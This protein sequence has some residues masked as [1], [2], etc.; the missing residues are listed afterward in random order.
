MNDTLRNST[1]HST[2]DIAGWIPAPVRS[3]RIQSTVIVILLFAVLP[4][5]YSLITALPLDPVTGAIRAWDFLGFFQTT[6]DSLNGA[7]LELRG[8]FYKPPLFAVLL[9]PLIP[10]GFPLAATIFQLLSIGM[11]MAV[12]I[13]LCRIRQLPLWVAA[14]LFLTIALSFPFAFLIDRGNVDAISLGIAFFAFTTH[15]S[16]LWS[17]LLFALS[18]HIKTNVLA[19]APALWFRRDIRNSANALFLGVSLIALIG[20][21]TPEWT[22][23]WIEVIKTR[24]SWDVFET[25]NGSLARAF[26]GVTGDTFLADTL[27]KLMALSLFLG[28]LNSIRKK[29]SIENTDRFL[30]LLPLCQAYPHVSYLYG[31]VYLPLTLVFYGQILTNSPRTSFRS[32]L[33]TLGCAGVVLSCFPAYLGQQIFNGDIWPWW[34][35]SLGLLC[36]LTANSVLVWMPS[37]GSLPAERSPDVSPRGRCLEGSVLFVLAGASLCSLYQIVTGNKSG[38]LW[39]PARVD[40]PEGVEITGT[41]FRAR[42]VSQQ[43]GFLRINCSVYNCAPMA[44]SGIP[45]ATGL[46]THAESRIELFLPA[47][48]KEFSGICGLDDGNSGKAA[49]AFCIV[50]AGQKVLYRSHP[51]T[52]KNP[53]STFRIPL[54]GEEKLT[55]IT[56][57]LTSSN[58]WNQID[59]VDLKTDIQPASEKSEAPQPLN[60]EEK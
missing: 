4:Y 33:A 13:V 31:Y 52:V 30:L 2:G 29:S 14:V 10:L 20:Y 26:L 7:P 9:S 5:I 11:I 42:M 28:L 59:W 56:R 12:T 53:V 48:A 25:E 57:N 3:R 49:G 44:I 19:L 39:F 18:V 6:A 32:F 47:G 17:A 55:L 22:F 54:S 37:A 27:L 23:E 16:T 60:S 58:S 41:P 34:L 1:D 24:I 46:G 45:Y 38:P 51:L 21:I 40:A 50:R 8:R 35:P 36:I 15:R 43:Y